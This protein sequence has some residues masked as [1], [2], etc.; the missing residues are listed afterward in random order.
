MFANASDQLCDI[1]PR[2]KQNKAV[3]PRYRMA[4][5]RLDEDLALM[6]I[7]KLQIYM[8]KKVAK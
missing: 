3:S 8:N 4:Q 6:M 5:T 7:L 1:H 2:K